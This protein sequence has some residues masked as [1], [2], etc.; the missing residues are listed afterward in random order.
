MQ[1]VYILPPPD[2]SLTRE[3]AIML[4][5]G[6][7]LYKQLSLVTLLNS[8]KEIKYKLSKKFAIIEFLLDNSARVKL[9]AWDPRSPSVLI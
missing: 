4:V 7:L 1:A 9:G 2:S 6:I 3:L 5:A 8:T